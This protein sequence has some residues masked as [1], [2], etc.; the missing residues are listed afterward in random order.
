MPNLSRKLD[1]FQASRMSRQEEWSA[2]RQSLEQA[3]IAQGQAQ[4][5]Q[6]GEFELIKRIRALDEQSRQ[7]HM[8]LDQAGVEIRQVE[9]ERKRLAVALAAAEVVL[10]EAEAARAS[11]AQRVE[12]VAR[13]LNDAHQRK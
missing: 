13:S 10:V 8:A 3:W 9:A 12:Q 6:G 1:E 2:L 5:R 7:D 11:L 4:E